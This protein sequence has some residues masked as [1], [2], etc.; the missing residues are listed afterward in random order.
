MCYCSYVNP[1]A[2]R[3]SGGVEKLGLAIP[4]VDDRVD[5]SGVYI[6]GRSAPEEVCVCANI[7]S[8]H[9]R[10]CNMCTV[11]DCIRVRFHD[12]RGAVLYIPGVSGDT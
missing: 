6:V 12:K 9:V 8:Y 11:S 7:S 1:A 3:L 2:I 4:V 5:C 10:E